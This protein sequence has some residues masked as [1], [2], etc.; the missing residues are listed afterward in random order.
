MLNGVL[1]KGLIRAGEL[2]YTVLDNM[3]QRNEND[4]GWIES[5]MELTAFW[6]EIAEQGTPSRAATEDRIPLVAGGDQ[7]LHHA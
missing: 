5:T 6:A 7:H 4:P 2:G 3:Y 1:H